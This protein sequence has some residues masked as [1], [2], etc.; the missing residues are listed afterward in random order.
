MTQKLALPL[1]L[2]P[3][4]LPTLSGVF[5]HSKPPLFRPTSRGPYLALIDT[6]ATHSWVSSEIGKTLE[7]HSLEGY[8]LPKDALAWEAEGVEVKFG[9]MKGLKGKPVRG[10]VQ[11]DS[12]L[13]AMDMLLFSG[14]V[15]LQGADLVL[16][17]DLLCSFI[18][19][20][21]VVSGPIGPATLVVES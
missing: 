15:E 10:F 8:I 20:G 5:V 16:G 3:N 19:C 21:L 14:D 13:P 17:M 2:L 7:P 9:F 6:G 1:S 18:Q 12:R 11:L 4:L